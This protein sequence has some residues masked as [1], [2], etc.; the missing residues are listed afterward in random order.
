MI[1]RFH[2]SVKT[3]GAVAVGCSAFVRPKNRHNS[4]IIRQKSLPPNPTL[5]HLPA[6]DHPAR[7]RRRS[8]MSANQLIQNPN[9]QNLSPSKSTQKEIQNSLGLTME[10]THA[11]PMTQ[12]AKAELRAPS[13]VVC[14][15]LVRLF[16]PHINESRNAV[17]ALFKSNASNWRT[18]V[19][20]FSSS[21]TNIR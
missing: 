18:G 9:Y 1:S 4:K 2:G 20:Q 8:K 5:P 13:G 10:L 14:S 12:S 6:A 11:G 21:T 7:A 15:D 19:V 17:S 3:E 16:L